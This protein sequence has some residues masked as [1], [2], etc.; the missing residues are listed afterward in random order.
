MVWDGVPMTLV[1]N[2]GERFVSLDM[3]RFGINIRYE[4]E[5]LIKFNAKVCSQ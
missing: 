5:G 1:E 3:R 4:I 2:K